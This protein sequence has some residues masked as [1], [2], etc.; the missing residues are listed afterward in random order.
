MHHYST[1]R[2]EEPSYPSMLKEIS[3]APQLFY[4]RGNLSLL[5]TICFA[6]VGTRNNTIQGKANAIHFTRGLVSYGFTIVSGLALGIDAIVHQTTLEYGGK[7]IAVLGNG[8]DEIHPPSNEWLG[9]LILERGGLILSEY[10]PNVRTYKHHFPA[11]NR[12]ISGLS[13]GT[14][15]IEAPLK[16]GALITAKRALEQNRE[17][18]ALP[19]ALTQESMVGN[20]NLIAR[21]G[22]RMVRSPEDIVGNLR[23]QPE[24]N[25]ESIQKNNRHINPVLDTNAQQKVWDVLSNEPLDADDIL[26]KTDLSIVDVDVALAYLRLKR[27]ARH[28]GYQRYVRNC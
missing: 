9:N 23:E 17:V 27:L 13:V 15:V 5:N 11:R 10:E 25:L 24:L 3:H 28:V 16:S 22:A 18:F 19:G 2:I 4:A 14:L 7:T 6:V 1:I 20:I 8:I 12:I 26:H 21:D